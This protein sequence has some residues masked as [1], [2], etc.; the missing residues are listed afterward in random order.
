MDTGY[1]H[2]LATVHNAAMSIGVHVSFQISVLEFFFS[3]Y[4][5]RSGISGSYSSSTFSFWRNLHTIFHSGCTNLRFPSTVHQGSLFSTF[6]PTFVICVLFDDS[7]SDRCE[8][9]MI[10]SVKHLF[11]C[12][13]VLCIS[14][15]EKCLFSSALFFFFYF[16][17]F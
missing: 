8:V 16:A 17:H 6:S 10:S 1:I 13:F 2:I 4:I 3:R 11:I 5:L 15:L 12:P 14:S 7:H 9:M